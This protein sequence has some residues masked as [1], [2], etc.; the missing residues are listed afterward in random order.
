L[1]KGDFDMAKKAKVATGVLKGA[2][3]C[4]T[5]AC[6]CIINGAFKVVSGGFGIPSGQGSPVEEAKELSSYWFEEAKRDFDEVK[7]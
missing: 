5:F 7:E 4:A 2:L 3:G 1:R 6:G